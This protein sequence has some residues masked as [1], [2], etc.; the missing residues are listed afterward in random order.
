MRV[1]EPTALADQFTSDDLG[2]LHGVV[3]AAADVDTFLAKPLASRDQ[4]RVALQSLYRLAGDGLRASG[5]SKPNGVAKLPPAKLVTVN[6]HAEQIW[7]Q[8]DVLAE[9]AMKRVRCVSCTMLS[10][11]TSET[12]CFIPRVQCNPGTTELF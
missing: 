4:C 2:A 12:N 6:F 11:I 9:A 3:K 8:I 5:D 1:A 10:M 7:G